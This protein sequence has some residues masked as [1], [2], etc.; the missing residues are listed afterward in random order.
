VVIVIFFAFIAVDEIISKSKSC[1]LKPE[2][3]EKDAKA[4]LPKNV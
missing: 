4:V 1:Q 2:Y 3:C